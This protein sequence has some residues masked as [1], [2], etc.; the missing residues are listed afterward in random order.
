M[1]AKMIQEIAQ[2]LFDAI[3][4]FLNNKKK[5]AVWFD[6]ETISKN[7]RWDKAEAFDDI[8]EVTFTNVGTAVCRVNNMPLAT[9]GSVVFQTNWNEKIV[10]GF[11]IVF[12]NPAGVLTN[13]CIVIFKRTSINEKK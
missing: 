11:E 1:I 13:N 6:S 12:I 2:K 4:G 3:T 10:G 7:M 5:T 9:N 8:V